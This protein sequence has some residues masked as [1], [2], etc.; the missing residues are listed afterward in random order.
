M[1][2]RK[3]RTCRYGY[4]YPNWDQL[5]CIWSGSW[6]ENLFPMLEK[7][8]NNYHFLQSVSR[9]SLFPSSFSV[10]PGIFLAATTIELEDRHN[11]VSCICAVQSR[12]AESNSLPTQCVS[13]HVAKTEFTL[14]VSDGRNPLR[15]KAEEGLFIAEE[16]AEEDLGDDAP[17]DQAKLGRCDFDLRSHRDFNLQHICFSCSFGEDVRP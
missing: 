11:S 6:V 10:A 16:H 8:F 2:G 5:I 1:T 17:A 3:E 9:S 14:R 7:S 15:I 12:V 4:G 13:Y